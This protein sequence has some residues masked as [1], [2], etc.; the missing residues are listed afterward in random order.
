MTAL[1]RGGILENWILDMTPSRSISFA[2]RRLVTVCLLAI[3]ATYAATESRLTSA[4]PAYGID[5][6]REAEGLPQS[7]IRAI[8]QTYDGYIWL[9]TDNGVVR[10]NGASFTAFTA[11]T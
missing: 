8:V 4:G 3:S 7:K 5:Y 9:G 1:L 2:Q 11:E 10:F 6:W